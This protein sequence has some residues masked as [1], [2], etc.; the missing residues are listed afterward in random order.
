MAAP[1]PMKYAKPFR[2]KY[3]AA[4]IL[5]TSAVEMVGEALQRLRVAERL[6]TQQNKVHPIQGKRLYATGP[7]TVELYHKIAAISKACNS[8]MQGL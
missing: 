4:P 7:D 6:V 5:V 3:K 1:G 2:Q 8:L